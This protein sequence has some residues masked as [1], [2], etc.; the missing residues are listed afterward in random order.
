MRVSKIRIENILGID[1]IEIH[2]GTLTM[3]EGRNASGKTSVLEAIK[4]AL[5]GGHDATLIRQGANAGEVVLVLE[6]GVEARRR[7]TDSSSTLVVKHPELG[8]ISKAQAYLERL[9]DQLSVNPIEFLTAP[10]KA[11]LE[12]L[13]EAIPLKVSASDLEFL[14]S[15]LISGCDLSAHALTVLSQLHAELYQA[16]ADSK[17]AL[18]EKLATA[19]QMRSSMPPEGPAG[20][21]WEAVAESYESALRQHEQAQAR[22]FDDVRA[23]ASSAAEKAR[24]E[25]DEV[26]EGIRM[27]ERES[28]RKITLA[29]ESAGQEIKDKLASARAAAAQYEKAESARTFVSGLE[30]A[31]ATLKVQSQVMSEH[32]EKLQA[33][34]SR[35]V[36]HLPIKGLEVA[37]GE[38]YIDGIPFDHVNDA[39][40]MDLAIE[41]AKLRGDFICV[42][43]LEQFDEDHLR[44][45]EKAILASGVQV[46]A[47]RVTAGPLSVTS[48]GPSEYEEL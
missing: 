19:S 37:D 45:F 9:F 24:I 47:S 22:A 13:L 12:R 35:I 1:E 30:E 3:I 31:A 15:H 38:I 26:I 46:I 27:E 40:K 43:G 33:L 11:R 14:P 2:P 18:K 42:D 36:D 17:R 32:L 21:H 4:A 29:A 8:K 48:K 10:P 16:R 41:V 34:K 44:M 6:D 23:Q 7:I 5:S 28:I 39:V 20:I 25:L